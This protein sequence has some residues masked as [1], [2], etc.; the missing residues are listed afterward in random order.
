ML[1]LMVSEIG[2]TLL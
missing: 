2:S 1:G